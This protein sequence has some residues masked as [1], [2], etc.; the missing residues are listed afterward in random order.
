VS[1]GLLVRYKIN[2]SWI[3]AGGALVGVMAQGIR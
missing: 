1:A 2:S 3:I